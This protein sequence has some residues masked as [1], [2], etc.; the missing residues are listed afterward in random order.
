MKE[1]TGKYNT[2]KVFTDDIDKNC[3]N[4]LS[5]LMNLECIKD[6]EIRIM[7]D[8]HAG[9]GCVI[10]TTMTLTDK[11]IPNLVGVDIGC[12]MLVIKLVEKSIDFAKLDNVIH[13]DI[14]SGRNI[15][16]ETDSQWTDDCESLIKLDSLIAP[17]NKTVDKLSIGTLGSG[18]HFIEV[19][20]DEDGYYYLVIHTGSR[21]LGVAICKYYQR[22]S[23]KRLTSN[24][25]LF[26]AKIAE[27]RMNGRQSE[28]AAMIA[29]GRKNF[30][31]PDKD[32]TY[33]TGNDFNNYLH[34]MDIARAFAI[35][36]RSAI[37]SNII[38]A[39]G[40]HIADFI[41]TVHNYI[42]TEHMILRKGAVSAQ[43]GERLII[44]L[45]MRDGS[46]ICVGKGNEDWN[47]SAPHGA[48]RL[49]SRSDAKRE[50][51]L[52]DFKE[53]M[54]GI[55]STSVCD[56]TIDESP[57]AYKPAQEIIGCIRDTVD[58][59]NI[60]KPVYNFKATK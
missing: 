34:D 45:N 6:S 60:I 16:T 50:I 15:H 43:R 47:Y 42:D 25:V 57:F 10:G 38:D 21:H 59:V 18:N 19:D 37:A 27:M 46:L 12:G 28:I 14:P 17:T 26:G 53:T 23:Y 48:G 9:S 7:S 2:C 40:W 56:E 58:I 13:T 24:E 44:P 8:C 49:L 36:N 33:V 4:Q 20:K 51:K 3:I 54:K 1:I 30:V 52:S 35:M 31:A 32:L 22:L 55:Y 39:M 41:E 29:E 11:V 5:E